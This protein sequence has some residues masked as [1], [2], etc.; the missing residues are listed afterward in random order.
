MLVFITELSCL[1]SVESLKHRIFS[2][3]RIFFVIVSC[4]VNR[5]TLSHY[6]LSHAPLLLHWVYL[7]YHLTISLIQPFIYHCCALCYFFWITYPLSHVFPFSEYIWISFLFLYRA[8]NWEDGCEWDRVFS[9]L[10]L[11]SFLVVMVAWFGSF[12]LLFADS[13]F[14]SFGFISWSKHILV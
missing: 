12:S 7:S 11:P 5:I 13:C 14:D 6:S 4:C 8:V 9:S 2:F 1:A 10:V 3:V